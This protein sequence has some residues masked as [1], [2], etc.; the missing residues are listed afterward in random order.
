MTISDPLKLC[1][2]V[3]IFSVKLIIQNIRVSNPDGVI[4]G[5]YRTNMA[6]VDL[7]RCWDSP[8]E[9]FHPTIYYT[10]EMVKCLQRCRQVLTVCDIHGHS[11]KEGVFMYG[12]SS[13]DGISVKT[14]NDKLRKENISVF[15]L[16]QI[17]NVK[18]KSFKLEYCNFSSINYKAPTMRT[19][20]FEELNISYSYSM[21]ASL[22]GMNGKHFS[23]ND[24][25]VSG[26]KSYENE[27]YAGLMITFLTL[28]HDI[29]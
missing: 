19:V 12:C 10:K 2:D 6:G 23:C 20:M 5:N 14:P 15:T 7:N 4:N 28:C 18:N 27:I 17:L 22:A 26:L 9:R 29:S 1:I 25:M 8:D 13:K 16:P 3:D 21:E 11:R 24:L